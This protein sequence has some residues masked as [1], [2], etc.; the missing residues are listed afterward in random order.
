[1]RVLAVRQAV[2]DKECTIFWPYIFDIA[3]IWAEVIVTRVGVSSESSDLV[4]EY[5]RRE[6][7]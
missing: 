4:R 1:M 2:Q 7:L 3:R 6:N 5:P